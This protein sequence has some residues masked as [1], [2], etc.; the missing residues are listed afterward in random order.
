[1]AAASYDQLLKQVEALKM[2]N[3]NL[4]QELEDNSNHLTKLETEASN[5]KEVLKQLQ[6]SIEDEAMASSGQIDLLERLKELNLESTSF[7]GVRLRPK[8]SVHSSGSRE[9][10]VSSRSG[11]CSPVPMGSFPRRGFMN[12]SRESTGYLEELEK[13]RSLL[14]AELE[15]EEKEKD[16]YYAQLQNLTKRIDSLPLTENFSLQTDMTRRQLEYEARQIRAAMEEQLGT[17]QDMEKRAQARVARIQQIEKDILRIRQLLQSQATEAERAPQTKHDAGSHETERQNEGQG[18]AEI[19]VAT[20]STIQGSAARMDHEITSVTSSSN[21]YS[22]PRRLTSHLGTKVTEDYKAQVEMVYSLLSMLGTHDKDDMSRTLLAMSSSQD[23]CI[24]MRQSGCLPLLIQLLHGN[25]KDSVLLGNSRGSKEARA[26]ASAALHN[27]IHSQPDDKRGRRE[28]R[29]LHLLEQIRAYCETCWEWQEAHEQ[30]MDQDKNPMPAPVDHQICPAVCVL[31]KLS[32]DEEHRHAMNELGGLQAIAELLQ[33]DCEMYGLTSDHYS[34]TLR[35]YAGMALT[36]LTFGDVANKATLC[37]MKGCMRALVAQLKSESE[38]LQQV[39]ASVLR[40]LSWRAD[41]NSKKTLREVGSVKA[42]MECALEVKKE[43]TLKSVLSALWNLSAHCTGN[44]AD[45]CAVDGALAFLV[46]TLT[47]RSQT[48]TLAIIESG[49]GILRN[50]SSLIATN[51]DH[52]QILRENSCLQTLLQHLKSHSLTIVSNACGTLW[53]LS[54]RNAKDQEALWDMGA[55]SMLKNLIHSKHK[56]IAMGSAAALRN[57]MANRPAKYKDANIMSPGSSLPSLHVRKQKALEAE[58]DAQH[59]SETFDNIDNLSPKASHR[60]KQRHKQNIYSEYVLDSSRNDDGIYRSESFNAGNVS[61]LSAYLNTA[62]LPGSSSSSRGNTENSRSEKDRSLDRER[63]VGLN[64]YHPAPENAGNSSKRMGMQISIATAQITKVMEDVTSVHIPQEDKSSVSTSEMHCLTED[65]NAQR[66][67]TT[68]HT[69]SNTYFPKSENSNRTCPVPYTKMEYKRASNDSLNSVSSSD[70]YGKRGQMKPSVE[71]YSEDDESKFCSYGKYPADLAHKI[72]SANHMDDNDGEL[73]TPI[74]YSLKYSDEQLNSGRQSPSQNERWTRPKHIVDD[75]MKQNEQRQSRS[76]NAAY[77]VYTE[78]G[79]DKHMKYQSPFGQQECVSSFR[80][81]GSSGSDQNRVGSTLG[82]SQKVNQSLCQVDDYDDDKPT[83]YS[84]RYSEEEQHE[85]EDRPTDYSIQYNEEEHH[86]D[87]PIDYSLKYSTEVPSSQKPSFTFPKTSSVQHSKTDHISSSSGSTSAPSAGSK[88]QNQLHPNSAQSRGGHAQKTGSCKTPSINQETIQTYCVEDTPICFSRCSSLS[89]LSSAEDEIGRNQSTHVTEA[90]NTLQISEL[91]ENSGALS[92]DGAV[93]ESTSTS[94]NIRTKS[95]R[96]QNSSL[97]PSDSTRHKVVEFSSGAKSPSKSGAQTPKSPPEHYVQET[98]LMFSRCTSVSSLDSFESR[99]IA[100]SVQSEPCSGIVSGIISPSDLPDSPGQTMPPSRSKTP[101]PAQGVQGKRDVAKGKI[102]SA[103]K[104]DPGPRQAAVNAA[105]QRVQVLPDADTLLHFATES[106]PDGFSCSSSLSALSLDEPFIQKDA[107]LRIMPPVHENEHGNEAELEQSDDT[108]D[109]QEEKSEK[110]VE[111]EKDILDDSDD[112]IEILEACIIS[113]MPT[114]SSRKAKKPSQASAPKI[115]PPVARK[116]SQLPVYKLLPSQSRLQSQKHVSFTPGDDMPRVYCVEGTPI[117]FSTATS[118]SDLTIESP[119]SELANADNVGTGVEPGEFE[120][121]DT[122]PTE[123]RST[124]DCQTAKISV[125]TSPGLDDDKTEEGDI[126][127]ECINSAMPKGKSHKP[128]RVKK[129]M[130]QIQQASSSLSNKSQPEGEK[131]KPTS[132]VKPVPQNDEYRARIRKTTEP[133]NSI[134]N[135]RSYPENRDTK[136]QNLKNNARDFNDK[137][138]NNEERVRGSFSFDSPH[139]YTP[140]EGTPYCFSRNDS[141]SSLDFD[142]DDVDLSREKAELRKGKETKETE[143]KDCTNPEQSS[144][145][146]PSNRT[147]VCQKNATGRSQAKTFSQSA[148]EIPDR[149]AATDEKMQDFAIENTP[150]CF[151]RNSSLSSLSDIDQ[152]NNNNKEGQ[153]VKS[154]ETPNSQMESNRP[155][156]SGYAPKS[157]HVEDTPVCFSRNSSL[158]SLSIDSEDDLL[159][160][161]ISS[162]MPK[163]KKPSRIKIESEKNNSRNAGN[164]LAEDLTLDLREIQRLDSEHGFSPDSENFDWK[165]IQE[166]ANSIVSSLHQA[167]AAASL[168]RQASSDSDSILSL[169]SGIS[170]GSPFHLT[171]DQEEKPFTSNKGPRILKPGEKSTLESKKAESESRGIKGGKKV[172]KSVITGKAH[173]SSEVSSQLK[174][175]QQTSVPSISRGRTM[176]HIPGVRNSSS[177]TSPVSKK[178]PALKNTNSKSPGEGQGLTSSPRGVKSSVKPEPAPVTRQ[179]SGLTQGGSSKGPSRSG[180][181]D[182]TPSRPQQ[183]PLSRPLQSPGRNSISPGRNGIS[184]PNK[185]SQLPRTSSPSTASTKSSSS[186]RMSYTSPGRQMSQQ[187]LTKQTALPKSTSSIPRSESTSKGLNQALNSGGSNKKTDLS[188]ISSTKSSGSESDRSERPVLVRQSTFIKEAPSPTLRRKLEE[189]ASFESLSPSR[190]DSPTRS[191]LQT[192]VLSPS[193]PD[194]SSSTHAT[195]QA[196]GWRKL[197][198]NMS[199]STEYDGRQAKRHDIARSHSESP[200][201]LLISRSGTWKREHSKHSSSLPRVSTWRRT[202]SSS[203]ILSASSESSEKAKSEDEKQHVSSLSGHKQCKESQAP[204]KGTW[205]KIKESEIPQIM[206]DPQHS[207]S[208][209]TSG[210]DSKSLIYQMA[211]AVSKTEDVWVR[212]EDCPIN[213][214]R[215]GR[216]PTGNTPPVIDSVLEKGG[217]SCKDSKEIQEKQTPGNGAVPVRT[218]GLENRLN[219]FFQMDSPDKGTETKPLPNNP[220]PTLENNE[221]TVSERTPFSSSSSS[222]H[223][224]PIGTVAARVTPFNYNPSRR[225]SSVDNSSAR[226]SQIPTPVNNSTKKRDSKSENPDSSGTQ[227]PKRHSGSYLVTS[228]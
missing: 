175:P 65:R 95:G 24:A 161:C 216:S 133:K 40:N 52:R 136:K 200:S 194:M 130:D 198:P 9:G 66:R 116:P 165:A 140:I 213:N 178:G 147:H 206:N 138:P 137:L 135:E 214:P 181:R 159:Q 118:L 17:C 196:S 81:R 166:G 219:S 7:P 73:D 209:A 155:L 125:V 70:G 131:K 163:K 106:T 134:N 123:G 84:E 42:L 177:S 189:S 183:Q 164:V 174:Q 61:V 169:K 168:S 153:P 143:T 223:S 103:E 55:V 195:A 86:V 146:Q 208:G 191:Q 6:G 1:M 126:L 92:T 62:V 69:H 162:A 87:Q 98:P 2:E 53:N 83:N 79:D 72:H 27:I 207:F 8:V 211:P 158:S 154:T 48:N 34:V 80:S 152:E 107:E 167:A 204:T 60:N 16:W 228:V 160:E 33:V 144:N 13:E 188:R 39:I 109:S 182:S 179:P 203:S 220:V 51:E 67:S 74:N 112:D 176:I 202:G 128:F 156:T 141:L 129:I 76:Q 38:D 210:S 97:S 127:A 201:R 36:N 199:P 111:T 91:K 190:P 32:F 170:L 117:N 115:P 224:S 142:D 180:S 217:V 193:L 41:V 139:H 14:L 93:N 172:Y 226:P 23:S 12:G 157:F 78:S 101:P 25:D 77:P 3:S 43:S 145:Q 56:M 35:R 37:S 119:P 26:R 121:R 96:L 82:I 21:N 29:V 122:I 100:S 124:D 71:S 44:K 89:S 148:K 185:L 59:L 57:L 22:V 50:V 19:S 10:S 90:S 102:P 218:I 4:R 28:I 149:G 47:Y 64:T 20:S 205:R 63:A 171:P 45:I 105:V 173:S 151:S 30:G 11:E 225:K 75:E 94:Q 114:K 85:E 132:P 113:A 18:A 110:P 227:S 108:K 54:A 49:G 68:A 104:R 186:S 192:P 215:S 212:I 197:P 5:M 46:S 150:V 88:R 221:S 120:K 31:M 187:N 15:K 58:L 222:K 184:P 99:S